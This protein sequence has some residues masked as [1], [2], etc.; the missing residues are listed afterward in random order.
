MDGAVGM[1]PFVHVVIRGCHALAVGPTNAMT[2]GI[3]SLLHKHNIRMLQ[4]VLECESG[5]SQLLVAPNTTHLR[6]QAP[7]MRPC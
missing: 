7:L 1:G 6:Q 4:D 2:H 5:C 3:V